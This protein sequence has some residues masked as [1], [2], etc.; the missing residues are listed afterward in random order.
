MTMVVSIY[1]GYRLTTVEQPNGWQVEIVKV[2]GGK[3]V[4]TRTFARMSDAIDDARLI[5]D[6]GVAG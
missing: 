5:V 6:R 1:N 3:P 2:G 4:L